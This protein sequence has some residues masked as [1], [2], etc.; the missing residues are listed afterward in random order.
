MAEWVERVD[1]HDRVLGVVER[2]EAIERRWLHRVATVVCRDAGGRVLVHR[3][4]EDSS[5]FPGAYNWLL[6]GGVEAGEGYV[7]AA[8]REL[9]EELGTAAPVP[10]RFK[11]LCEGAIS[12]Y[13][14]GVHEALITGTPSPDR[15]EIAWWG[16][17][18]EESL[19]GLMARWPFVPDSV[20]AFA[21]YRAL[22]G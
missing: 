12:P 9:A 13:W 16:W 19:P 4:P 18:E 14:L 11:F 21:R 1:E 7:A 3:R 22:T 10:F 17:V 2:G 20:E 6:G 8:G 15:R 5:R